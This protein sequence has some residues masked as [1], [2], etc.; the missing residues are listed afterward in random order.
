MGW[1]GETALRL[2]FVIRSSLDQVR[3]R[4]VTCACCWTSPQVGAGVRKR[5]KRQWSRTGEATQGGDG[6]LPEEPQ[7][8]PW[9]VCCCWGG[10]KP[11]PPACEVFAHIRVFYLGMVDEVQ[12]QLA[13]GS[14]KVYLR[15][16]SDGSPNFPLR[17]LLGGWGG[18]G[19]GVRDG[20]GLLAACESPPLTIFRIDHQCGKYPNWVFTCVTG[21]IN[22]VLSQD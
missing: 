15:E 17:M 13:W 12:E 9:Q 3:K 6:K 5:E 7:P 16:A 2:L 10:P 22:R 20:E 18:G 19:G 11:F 14:A 8:G 21:E 4:P 1:A